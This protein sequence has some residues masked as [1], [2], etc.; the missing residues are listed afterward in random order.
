MLTFQELYKAINEAREWSGNYADL[1][2][3]KG[4]I[5]DLSGVA[6]VL[7]PSQEPLLWKTPT[8]NAMS[9]QIY[10]AALLDNGKLVFFKHPAKFTR[11]NILP[12]LER[13]LKDNFGYTSQIVK[14]FQVHPSIIN[15]IGKQ[16]STMEEYKMA[17]GEKMAQRSSKMDGAGERLARVAAA[18]QGKSYIDPE[19]AGGTREEV[20]AK[21]KEKANALAKEKMKTLM[22]NGVS[23]EDALSAAKEAYKKFITDYPNYSVDVKLCAFSIKEQIAAQPVF[24]NMV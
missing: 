24:D 9:S 10:K 12:K 15:K 23:R 7:Y 18:S 11:E 1:A 14:I 8:R 16:T 2:W 22:A 6:S 20:T 4:G 21:I 3:F 13:Y 5:P 19:L 17:G